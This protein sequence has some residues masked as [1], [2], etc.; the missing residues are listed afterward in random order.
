METVDLRKWESE[1]LKSLN[2]IG[3]HVVYEM[4]HNHS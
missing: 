2:C 4:S 3:I 1:V